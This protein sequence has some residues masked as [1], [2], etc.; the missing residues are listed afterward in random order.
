MTE[1]RLNDIRNTLIKKPDQR[2]YPEDFIFRELIDYI[3]TLKAELERAKKERDT[4]ASIPV[5]PT[6]QSSRLSDLEKMLRLKQSDWLEICKESDRL[7]AENKVLRDGL[8]LYA[9]GLG[10]KLKPGKENLYRD[11]VK[12]GDPGWFAR[13]MSDWDSKLIAKEALAK[14]DRL[15]DGG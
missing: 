11:G 8:E 4:V 5:S 9:N 1:E 13:S 12:M 15:R 14:A 10:L 2:H 6:D 7:R 3:D